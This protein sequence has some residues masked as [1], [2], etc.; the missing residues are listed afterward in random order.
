VVA[1]I[2]MYKQKS[3]KK[4]VCFLLGSLA[5][6][7]WLLTTFGVQPV[8]HKFPPHSSFRFSPSM[9][10]VSDFDGDNKL[11]R[12]KL[13]SNGSIKTISVDF[14]SS[15]WKTLSFDS[16]VEDS[17]MLVS[18]DVDSDGDIDLVWYSQI[19]PSMHV[20]W[21]GD[22]QGNFAISQ[23]NESADRWLQSSLRD[24]CQPGAAKAA[25][26]SSGAYLP[27]RGC[28]AGIPDIHR[29]PRLMLTARALPQTRAPVTSNPFFYILQL[30]GPPSLIS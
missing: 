13:Y 8:A 25:N 9:P 15:S 29:E 24:D 19:D 28:F 5:M 10:V 23:S 17:G 21:L 3:A 11:D 1:T 27:P 16:G 4:L 6:G 30:R 2:M 18:G 12:A 26:S 20:T 22:G 7:S 14:G